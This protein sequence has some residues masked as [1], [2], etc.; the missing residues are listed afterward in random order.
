MSREPELACIGL[1][2]NLGAAREVLDCAM[3]RLSALPGT[4]RITASGFYRTAPVDAA[5]PDF[6]NAVLLLRTL[7][8]PEALLDE[9]QRIE[10][11]HGRQRPYRN[12]PRT[13]DLDLLLY[14]DLRI[15]TP[16]LVV[17]HP[18]M[19][20]RAFVLHPLVEVMPEAV[21]PGVGSAR[22]LLPA[23]SDQR[24]ERLEEK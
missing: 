19:H 22:E 16:R 18:R 3:Q 24:I 15:A 6:L 11:E 12:A 9:L 10:R 17:P 8:A 4:T 7:L 21:I 14:G 13:L 20:L 2:A 23:V 1:G 5:G